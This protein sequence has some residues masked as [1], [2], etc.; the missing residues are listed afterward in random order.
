MVS[1]E[2]IPREFVSLRTPI[3]KLILGQSIPLD[4]CREDLLTLIVRIKAGW[5]VN[6]RK[7]RGCIYSSVPIPEV[8]VNK[9]WFD[10]AS[11]GL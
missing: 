3:P 8:P 2:V 5:I 1:S 11:I 7:I 9:T 6:Q 4:A 10:R